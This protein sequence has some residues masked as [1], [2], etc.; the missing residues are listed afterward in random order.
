MRNKKVARLERSPFCD[1]RVTPPNWETFLCINTLAPPA[2]STRSRR[3]NKS[4]RERSL[5]QS[6]L[7]RALLARAKG[8][9][10]FPH[11]NAR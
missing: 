8:S 11:I 6:E 4:M 7:A 10:L 9:T 5:S 1:D 2:G 3:A